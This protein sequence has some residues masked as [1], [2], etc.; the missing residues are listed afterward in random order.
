[1][2]IKNVNMLWAKQRDGS[3]IHVK[4]NHVVRNQSKDTDGFKY[5]CFCH[6]KPV[7]S[8]KGTSGKVEHHF[9]HYDD[10]INENFDL[11]KANLKGYNETI[12]HKL[13][14]EIIANLDSITIPNPHIEEELDFYNNFPYEKDIEGNFFKLN[15]SEVIKSFQFDVNPE[16]SLIEHDLDNII[17]DVLIKIKNSLFIPMWTNLA[18]EIFV[19]HSVDLTKTTKIKEKNLFCIQI[20][21]S[22]FLNNMDILNEFDDTILYSKLKDYILNPKL[23]EFINFNLLDRLTIIKNDYKKNYQSLLKKHNDTIFHSKSKQLFFAYDTQT[24]RPVN[25]KLATL[26]L[27]YKCPLCS[28]GVLF[29]N[30]DNINIFQHHTYNKN[31]SL[32]TN[33]YVTQL[34]ASKIYSFIILI[35]KELNIDVLSYSYSEDSYGQNKINISYNL[36]IK[37]NHIFYNILISI[38]QILEFLYQDN[39]K[40]LIKI[41]LESKIDEAQKLLIENNNKKE[42]YLFIA[43]DIENNQIITFKHGNLNKKYECLCCNQKLLF[44]VNNHFYHEKL[45]FTCFSITSNNYICKIID[46]IFQHFNLNNINYK[47]IL[48]NFLY[49]E[50]IRNNEFTMK[51]SYVY[52]NLIYSGFKDVQLHYLLNYINANN[53]NNNNEI[54]SF[55]DYLCY[56]VDKYINDNINPELENKKLWLKTIHRWNSFN[57]LIKS[58]YNSFTNE[59]YCPICSGKVFKGNHRNKSAN[60]YFLTLSDDEF[61]NYFN[62]AQKIQS[63]VDELTSYINKN[64]PFH[65]FKDFLDNNN[66][67]NYSGKRFVIKSVYFSPKYFSIKMDVTFNNQP[68]CFSFSLIEKNHFKND[69]HFQLFNFNKNDFK[70]P[71]HISEK[72]KTLL[73]T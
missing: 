22:N 51:F 61:N 4:N 8:S 70:H 53:N 26:N 20:N 44:S 29:T 50:S 46:D 65:I 1:M 47:G 27:H 54:D 12:V 19:S 21:C 23:F 43:K 55:I 30:I 73:N 25:L 64:I 31:C 36:Y 45:N 3:K 13:A 24:S 37:F 59:C 28:Q 11:Y 41:Y 66:I 48:V 18:V 14:K 71:K 62:S 72:L 60:C 57:E 17:P 2:S 52:K 68:L 67:K 42:K 39:Y 69:L 56:P 40:E 38:Y 6:D 9:R 7:I 5:H 34:L 32:F 10:S 49:K 33:Q 15:S 63:L 35:F 16:Y 58:G